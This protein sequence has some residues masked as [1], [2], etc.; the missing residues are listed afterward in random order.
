MEKKN[1][2]FF[3]ALLIVLGIASFFTQE[4]VTFWMLAFV[5]IILFNIHRV[6]KEV[7]AKLDKRNQDQEN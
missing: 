5:I 6:L 2:I 4:I 3:T 1:T 7:S